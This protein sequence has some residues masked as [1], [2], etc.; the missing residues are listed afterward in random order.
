MTL[1]RFL[2]AAFFSLFS[3]LPLNAAPTLHLSSDAILPGQTLRVMVDGLDPSEKTRLSFANGFYSAFAVGPDAQRALIG[4]R[5]D[6]T[7]GHY[8]L[9]LQHFVKSS[10]R[11][12][13]SAEGAIEITTKTFTI[14]NVNFN[15]EKTE[16]MKWEHQEGARIHKLL[17]AQ[18]SQQLWEGMFDYPV[19]GPIIGEFGLKRIRNNKIDAGFHK[20]YDLKAPAG[21]PILAPAGGIIMMASPLKAHG[22]TVL[23][24]HGQGVMTIYL[25]LKSFNVA[26]GQKVVKGEKIG[27][28][29]S[30]GMSTA[31][32]VHWGLYVHGVAVDAKPW[33]ENEF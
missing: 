14:E 25:H 11:W 3:A 32:H 20:G 1:R 4:I 17:V 6:A 5:L 33:T 21:T 29:G 2:L 24:N 9:K 13:P 28:V 30:T 23:I 7:P 26:P 18:S 22:R 10:G 12:E 15:E 31:P 27:L 19:Q 16:L 8:P